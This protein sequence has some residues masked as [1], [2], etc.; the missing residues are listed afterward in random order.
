MRADQS[1]SD[2][3]NA[4]YYRRWYGRSPVQS[5]KKIGALADATLSLAKWWG[6]PMRSVLDVGA[7]HGWWGRH[8]ATAAPHIRYLGTDISAHACEKYGLHQ[9]DIVTWQ[10]P[11]HDLVVCQG[12]LHYLA[13]KDCV[14][15]LDH[16]VSATRGLLLLEIPTQ[17]DL[18]SGTIDA[19][20]SDLD[21]Y[22]RPA[23]WYRK[24]LLTKTHQIGAG[25]HVPA[26]SPYR[27]Y[28]LEQSR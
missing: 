21:A 4:E 14:R 22:W 16:L 6:I 24:K 18:D 7:G 23:S 3:F 1:R 19:S 15:A 9:R 10:P 17:D 5:A 28:A 12:T 25:L 8:L 13:D 27:F 11:K 2:R 20:A 26:D